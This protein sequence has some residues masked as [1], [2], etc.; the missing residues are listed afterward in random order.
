MLNVGITGNIGSGK[1]TVCRLFEILGTPV[2]YADDRGKSIS[3]ENGLVVKQVKELFGEEIYDSAGALRRSDVAAI[4]FKDKEKLEALNSIIHPA[5]AED[6][7]QWFSKQSGGGIPYALKEAALIVENESY[8]RLDKLI[9]VSAPLALRLE[10]VIKRD[11]SNKE[12]VEARMANQLSDEEKE[13][14]ADYIV[15]ND[16]KQALISQVIEI[17]KKLLSEY[18]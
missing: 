2:Y 3:N 6:A 10:R 8:K 18:Q 11:N 16:G 9:V 1:T 14:H 12:Q 7:E 4:V 15:V 13:K 5:V 17:H